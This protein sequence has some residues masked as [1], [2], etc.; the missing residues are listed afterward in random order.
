MDSVVFLCQASGDLVHILQ[1]AHKEHV[2]NNEL[3]ILVLCMDEKLLESWNFLNVDYI[4]VRYCPRYYA[5]ISKPFTY[6]HWKRSVSA[7]INSKIVDGNKIK[8]IYFTSIYDDPG[9]AYYI[10]ILSKHNFDIIYLNHY[11][12]KQSIVPLKHVTFKDKLRILMYR[13]MTGIDFKLYYMSGRWNVI[14][15]PKENYSFKEISS[16]IEPSFLKQYA[17]RLDNGRRNVLVFSQ[18]NR[19]YDLISDSEYDKIFYDV[20][21]KLKESG[22]YVVQKG[23]PRLGTCHIVD[24]IVDYTIPASIPSELVNYDSFIGCYGYLTIA[25]ASSAKMGVNSYSILPL[26][27]DHETAAYKGAEKFCNSTSDGKLLYVNQIDDIH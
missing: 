20:V 8:R 13:C 10:H 12:D 22:Y 4:G 11:D 19:D 3:A 27:K 21:I 26:T 17:F 24:S 1:A 5:P 6:C 16:N 2:E 15:F 23:H 14:R 18:P 9:T 25:L 7:L